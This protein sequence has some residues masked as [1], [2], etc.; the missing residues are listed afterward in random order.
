MNTEAYTFFARK[1]DEFMRDIPY[2]K[3]AGNIAAVLTSFE[4][5]WR[6]KSL[7]SDAE[8]VSLRHSYRN[9]IL[10]CVG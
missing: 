8:P 6:V 5:D 9:T 3:W 2:E 1:Y 7:N 10:R 4:L